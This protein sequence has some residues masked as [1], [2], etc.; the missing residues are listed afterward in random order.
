MN[1][2]KWI[3]QN[4]TDEQL[5]R[6]SKSK[7]DIESCL[8]N[9]TTERIHKRIFLATGINSDRIMTKTKKYKLMQKYKK[10]AA[11]VA[12]V[13]LILSLSLVGIYAT[14]ESFRE[15]VWSILEY[16]HLNPEDKVHNV[17]SDYKDDLKEKVKDEMGIT[18]QTTSYEYKKY[19]VEET[20]EFKNFDYSSITTIKVINGMT[21]DAVT[22]TDYEMIDNII[23][24]MKNISGSSPISNKGYYGFLYNVQMYNDNNELMNVGF[25]RANN[26]DEFVFTYGIFEEVNGYKYPCRYTMTGVDTGELVKIFSA[27]FY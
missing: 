23:G 17:E 1:K 21:G 25:M 26:P 9:K 27:L 6:L 5:A 13:V 4:L 18:D 22:I 14:N 19:T 16:W 24:F 10:L 15:S 12:C 20:V 3:M 7:I 2:M 11:C 8:D